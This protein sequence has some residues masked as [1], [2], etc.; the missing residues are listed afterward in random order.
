MP[1]LT[2]N[3]TDAEV[4]ARLFEVRE[5]RKAFEREEEELAAR[6]RDRG[7][8]VWAFGPFAVTVKRTEPQPRLS[9]ERIRETVAPA[10][11]KSCMVPGTASV[12]VQVQR[13][14]EPTN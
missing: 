5:S 13:V 9:L 10:I 12:S 11:L 8:G 6:F 7:T 3:A 4:A 2:A 1:P 14:G